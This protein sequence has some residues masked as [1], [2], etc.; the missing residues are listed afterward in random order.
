MFVR[1]VVP[2]FDSESY[3]ELGVFHAAGNLYWSGRMFSYEETEYERIRDW[4]SDCLRRPTRFTASKRPYYR[5]PKKA[6]CWFKD[7]AQVH[8][9]QVR[10]MVAILENHY[11]P[12]R[13]LTAKRVGYVVYEDKYQVAAQP[14]IR[15]LRAIRA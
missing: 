2:Q 1:F 6:I 14:F 5:K 4:F 8:L 13:M 12:V 9:D 3:C 10:G 7:T 15:E 11:V